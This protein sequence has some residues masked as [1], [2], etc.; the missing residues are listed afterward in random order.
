MQT[1]ACTPAAIEL[2]HSTAERD[3]QQRQVRDGGMQRK[4]WWALTCPILSWLSALYLNNHPLLNSL[5]SG[6]GHFALAGLQ[7]FL[8]FAGLLL[9]VTSLRRG[10]KT[11]GV[12]VPA[13]LAVLLSL[14][15]L[16]LVGLLIGLVIVGVIP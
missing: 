8:I 2:D 11:R 5:P 13:G 14:G 9:G 10:R 12:V 1:K 6:L 15:T 4:A 16:I 7:A 3:V